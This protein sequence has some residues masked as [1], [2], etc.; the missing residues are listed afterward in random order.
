MK[1]QYM[2]VWGHIRLAVAIVSEGD[3][4][5]NPLYCL[6]YKFILL[7]IFIDIC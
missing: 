5:P 1:C 7:I 4:V 3:K 6:L 2:H